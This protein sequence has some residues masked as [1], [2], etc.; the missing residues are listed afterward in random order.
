MKQEEIRKQFGQRIQFL[1]KQKGLNQSEL[2]EAVGIS[3]EQVSNI[4]RATSRTRIETAA[5]IAMALDVTLAD[6]FDL[7]L[8]DNKNKKRTAAIKELI[9][10]L[11]KHDEAFIR[12]IHNQAKL[13]V[14]HWKKK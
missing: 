4:E 5:S 14:E 8:F 1:R 10:F 12:Y 7:P 11:L 13:A 2:A 9:A 6:L 3:T